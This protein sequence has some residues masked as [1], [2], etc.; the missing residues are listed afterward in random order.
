MFNRDAISDG[1]LVYLAAMKARPDLLSP[2][3]PLPTRAEID[4]IEQGVSFPDWARVKGYARRLR[5]AGV[6]CR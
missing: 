5:M 2:D 1:Y 6:I 4:A 3:L